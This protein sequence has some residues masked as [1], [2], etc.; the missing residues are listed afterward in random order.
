MKGETMMWPNELGLTGLAV[1]VRADNPVAAAE[2]RRRLEPELVRMIRHTLQGGGGSPAVRRWIQAEVDR[3]L[4]E[5]GRDLAAERERLVGRVAR[6]LCQSVIDGLRPH[7]PG[8]RLA[9]ETVCGP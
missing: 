4:G 9:E 2:M 3:A 8:L 6:A 1:H 7:R 5:G